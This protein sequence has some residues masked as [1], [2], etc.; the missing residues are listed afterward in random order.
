MK[1]S[2]AVT[3][4]TLAVGARPSWLKS[5]LDASPTT[6]CAEGESWPSFGEKIAAEGA[7]VEELVRHPGAVSPS[8]QLRIAPG[9]RVEV[10]STHDQI[11]GGPDRQVY[12]GCRFPAR[13]AYRAAVTAAARRVADVLAA[14]GVIGSFGIDFVVVPDGDR[15]A[16]YLSEINL[17]LGGTTHPFWMARLVTGGAY[18]E[19]QGELLAG[20]APRSYVATD[21]LRSPALVGRRPAEVIDAVERLG[22][23]FDAATGTGVTLH[24]LG[25]LPRY[26]KMGAVCIGRSPEEADEYTYTPHERQFVDDWTRSHVIGDVATVRAGLE[27]LVERT[28]ADELMV[29]TMAPTH[30]ERVASYSRVADAFAPSATR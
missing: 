19:E 17:R 20:G 1:P 10:L 16:V 14:K 29:S 18:D 23:G 26:G 4:L 28:G 30:A 27:S 22:L 2:C 21:N 5:P 12:L 8:A 24:L 11:L 25:A 6:F 15:H 13:D 9:G 3:K 7:I